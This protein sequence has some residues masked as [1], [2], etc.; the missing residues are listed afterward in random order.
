MVNVK[1]DY[2]GMTPSKLRDLV[3]EIEEYLKKHYENVGR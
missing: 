2:G 3:N 1:L